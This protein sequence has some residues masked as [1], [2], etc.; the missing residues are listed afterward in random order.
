MIRSRRT[1]LPH[2]SSAR[3]QSRDLIEREHGLGVRSAT[4]PPVPTAVR[5]RISSRACRA[6]MH[7]TECAGDRLPLRPHVESH[8]ALRCRHAPIPVHLRESQPEPRELHGARGHAAKSIEQRAGSK[9]HD[10]SVCQDV[11]SGSENSEPRAQPEPGKHSA[12]RQSRFAQR[13][14]GPVQ[15]EGSSSRTAPV[16]TVGG[17]GNTGPGS[18]RGSNSEPRDRQ[19][20]LDHWVWGEGGVA[21]RSQRNAPCYRLGDLAAARASAVPSRA[22]DPSR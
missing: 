4:V 21:G 16:R 18:G 19:G 6:A 12:L 1:K 20:V 5:R 17:T 14:A 13:F 7:C 3:P 10:G 15:R 9:Q 22:G 11:R 8:R 2:S